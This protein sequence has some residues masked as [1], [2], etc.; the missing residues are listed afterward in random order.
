MQI[1]RQANEQRR[2]F[3]FSVDSEDLALYRAALRLAGQEDALYSLAR[4]ISSSS[5]WTGANLLSIITRFRPTPV[6]A[7]LGNWEQSNLDWLVVQ[8]QGMS[9]NIRRLLYVDYIMAE[10]LCQDLAEQLVGK[11]GRHELSSFRFTAIPRGGL[12]V[13]GMLAYIL[14]LERIQ[15]ELPDAKDLPL[16]VVDDCAYTG[17]RFGHF[18]RRRDGRP[19]VLAT[20][21]SHPDLRAAIQKQESQVIACVN[22]KDLHDFGRAQGGESYAVW[23]AGWQT[24]LPSVVRYWVGITEHVCF[25]WGEPDQLLW[26]HATEQVLYGWNIIPPE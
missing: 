16:V 6:L 7:F 14:G 3:W 25:A 15:I 13:L 21:F 17:A 22:A 20:L 19:V 12:V 11:F 9:Q 24:R 26:N 23:Q 18:I 10:Q 1:V 8:A 5:I 2:W 4:S